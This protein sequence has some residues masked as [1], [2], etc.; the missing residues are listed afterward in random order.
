MA[1]FQLTAGVASTGALSFLDASGNPGIPATVAQ[2][3][4]IGTSDPAGSASL[5]ADG[6]HYNV[7]SSSSTP[8]TLT[9]TGPLP[10]GG[11]FTATQVFDVV[12][13]PVNFTAVSATF[14]APSPGTTA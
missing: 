14:G 3:A 1:D 11:T 5:S 8:I 2:G 12:A 9:Y 13:A 10:T 7:T 4:T 6:T